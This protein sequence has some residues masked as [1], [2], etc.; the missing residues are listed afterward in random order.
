MPLFLG[1]TTAERLLDEIPVEQ[2]KSYYEGPVENCLAS[3]A[4]LSKL[5]LQLLEDIEKPYDVLVS[6]SNEMRRWSDVRC[7]RCPRDLPHR[8]FIEIADDV[9]VASPALCMVLRA[10]EL[11]LQKTMLLG[12]RSP[13][14]GDRDHPC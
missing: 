3:Q 1:H 9:Y 11:S 5:D 2:M 12:S 10:Q 4:A 13:R 8:A 7:H 14:V 6:S